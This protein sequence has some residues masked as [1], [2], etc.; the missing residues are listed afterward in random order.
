MQ[1][2]L[3][4]DCA[5]SGSGHDET[6]YQMWDWARHLENENLLCCYAHFG[7]K[8]YGKLYWPIKEIEPPLQLNCEIIWLRK[9]SCME[10]FLCHHLPWSSP[11]FMSPNIRIKTASRP[12]LFRGKK[13]SNNIQFNSGYCITVSAI[14]Q[15]H[16]ILISWPKSSQADRRNNEVHLTSSFSIHHN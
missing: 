3:W 10:C 15:K 7:H 12:L 13:S 11:F 16:L 14:S 2:Q 9:K 1:C 5:K 6:K 8:I 4:L